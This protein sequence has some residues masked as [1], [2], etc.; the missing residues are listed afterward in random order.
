MPECAG[1][2]L[3]WLVQDE[4]DPDLI[5][6]LHGFEL[7]DEA[8]FVCLIAEKAEEVAFDQ[9]MFEH[10]PHPTEHAGSMAFARWE[11]KATNPAPHTPHIKLT[12][13]PHTR[14]KKLRF[15]NLG[16]VSPT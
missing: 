12:A 6:T 11:K 1:L 14:C 7:D 5:E 10:H 15:K 3:T 8:T 16:P 2:N 13:V 4:G 9:W